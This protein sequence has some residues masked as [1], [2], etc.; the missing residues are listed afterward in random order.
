MPNHQA[1][2]SLWNVAGAIGLLALAVGM[3]LLVV[4]ATAW[5]RQDRTRA[6]GR[7]GWTIVLVG[8]AVQLAHLSEHIAQI[9]YWLGHP[10][11]PGWMTPWGSGVA[12]GLGQIDTSKP[13]LGMEVMHFVGNMAFL[14]GLV[15][16]LLLTRSRASHSEARRWAKVGV[17]LQ[18]AHGVEHLALMLSVWLGAPRAIGVSTWFGLMDPGPGLWTY[19]VWWHFFANIIGSAVFAITVWHLRRECR[20]L[21]PTNGGITRSDRSEPGRNPVQHRMRDAVLDRIK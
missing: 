12:T 11:S 10:N 16:A 1:H 14:A 2:C 18:S 8:L 4:R 13:T 21:K 19:R 15:G 6:A 7:A 3:W 20:D 9:G 17:W 5:D